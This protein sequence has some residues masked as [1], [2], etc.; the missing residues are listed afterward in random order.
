MRVGTKSDWIVSHPSIL[1]TSFV[2][3]FELVLDRTAIFMIDKEDERGLVEL[4]EKYMAPILRCVG[5][6]FEIRGK[7]IFLQSSCLYLS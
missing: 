2:G 6:P 1:S 7:T 3:K 4:V 5:K